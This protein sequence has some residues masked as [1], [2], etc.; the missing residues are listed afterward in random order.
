MYDIRGKLVQNFSIIDFSTSA[1][2]LECLFWGNGIVAITTDMQIFIAEV[3]STPAR[4][5]Q[6][7]TNKLF[8]K[9]CFSPFLSP[10]KRIKSSLHSY[11][12]HRLDGFV[13]ISA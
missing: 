4:V 13:T 10:S 3:Y 8:D 9:H 11:T 5:L 7:S 12:G 1:N 2:V 6:I